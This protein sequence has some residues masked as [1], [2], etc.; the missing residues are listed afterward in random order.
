MSESTDK[1]WLRLDLAPETS[2]PYPYWSQP[3]LRKHVGG[4]ADCILDNFLFLGDLE[5]CNLDN[6]NRLGITHVISLVCNYTLIHVPTID[7]STHLYF[8]VED[9]PKQSLVDV[10]PRANRFLLEC[11]QKN[12]RV[13]VHCSAGISRSSSIVIAF[14]MCHHNMTLKEAYT[15]VQ[16]KRPVIS[17]N[18]GFMRQ[19]SQLNK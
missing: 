3:D 13:L 16:H 14:L 11:Q 5:S 2:S 8:N 6:L 7:S 19:L 10:F 1:W 12:Q 18:L 4:Q 17:P 15:F 9:S